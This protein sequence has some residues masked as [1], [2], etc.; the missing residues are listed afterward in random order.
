MLFV[1]F[2]F[3]TALGQNDNHLKRHCVVL[4]WI[5]ELF[6]YGEFRC[7]NLRLRLMQLSSNDSLYFNL[8]SV[9][10]LFKTPCDFQCARD[11]T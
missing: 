8:H 6:E 10:A 9:D 1:C 2:Q 4:C 3:F 5:A 7:N 11:S